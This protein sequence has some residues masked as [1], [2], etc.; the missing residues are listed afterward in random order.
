MVK[1]GATTVWE[2]YNGYDKDGHPLDTSFN[3]YS[4]G[5]V[6]SFL[7]EYICGIRPAGERRFLLK[8]VPGG[9]LSF[10]RA[11]WNSP[12][13]T[14]TAKWGKEGKGF[15]YEVEVP[16]NCEADIELP[17]GQKRHVGAGRHEGRWTM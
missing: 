14:V 9:T 4:P 10:A 5:A 11:K 17:D 1:Q 6:C 8:P 15:V 3:H 12:Y 7:F 2:H 13:G 16:A